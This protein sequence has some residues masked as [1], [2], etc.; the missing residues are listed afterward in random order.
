M[1]DFSP[2]DISDRLYEHSSCVLEKF[3]PLN[4]LFIVFLILLVIL[5][6]CA[7]SIITSK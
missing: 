4:F 3:R 5:N 1:S 2:K 7:K 6:M